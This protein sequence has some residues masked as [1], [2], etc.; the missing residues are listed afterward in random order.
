[1][2]EHEPQRPNNYAELNKAHE[3][4]Q[5]QQ[6]EATPERP[7]QVRSASGWSQDASMAAQQQSAIERNNE[8]NQDWKRGL[9]DRD[10]AQK[11]QQDLE[12]ERAS[13][14]GNEGQQRDQQ[15]GHDR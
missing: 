2:P 14:R 8:I 15:T 11:M 13:Q 10:Y 7:D 1:M 9:K 5:R 12:Q 3:D 6:Q 4:A